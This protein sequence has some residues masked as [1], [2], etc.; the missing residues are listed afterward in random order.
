M[1]REYCCSAIPLVN[2]GIYLTLVENVVMSSLVGIFT[3]LRV[4]I[5]PQ[6]FSEYYNFGYLSLY[7]D[8]TYFKLSER[9]RPHLHL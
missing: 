5:V 9:L 8:N 1:T 7:A 2:A 3:L 6:A 4:D